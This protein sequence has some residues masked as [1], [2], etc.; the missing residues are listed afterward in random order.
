M[1][2]NLNTSFSISGRYIENQSIYYVSDRSTTG[3]R[4]RM[5]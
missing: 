1:Q 4:H 2:L 5:W 3:R